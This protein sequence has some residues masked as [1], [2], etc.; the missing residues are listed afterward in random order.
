MRGDVAHVVERVGSVGSSVGAVGG[1]KFFA[2]LFAQAVA[3]DRCKNVKSAELGLI[4]AQPLGFPNGNCDPLWDLC[5]ISESLAC[6]CFRK[7]NLA[8]VGD[9]ARQGFALWQCAKGVEQ[10]GDDFILVEIADDAEFDRAFR[11][12]AVEP[13][14]RIA[15]FVGRELY[16][17]GDGEARVVAVQPCRHFHLRSGGGV[18]D[19]LLQ[20]RN[21]FAEL[22]QGLFAVA[23]IGDRRAHE[24]QLRHQVRRCGRAADRDRVLGDRHGRFDIFSRKDLAEIVG[25]VLAKS[26]TFEDRLGKRIEHRHRAWLTQLAAADACQQTDFPLFKFAALEVDA[27]LVGK[28]QLR[29]AE[30]SDFRL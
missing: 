26:A 30:I 11:E 20:H 13:I 12:F 15:D 8:E 5:L 27:D 24:L 7:F 22:P 21:A 3:E 2:D 25:R 9:V 17:A 19:L 10:F 14:F 23:R 28:H 16:F 1:A 6:G 18:L 29:D 4:S